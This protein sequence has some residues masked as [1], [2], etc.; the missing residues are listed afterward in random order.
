M[1]IVST[2]IPEVDQAVVRPAL[3]DILTQ[4]Q[5]VL[6]LPSDTR[7]MYP[8]EIGVMPVAGSYLSDEDRRAIY[9][10]GKYLYVEIDETYNEDMMGSTA[11]HRVEHP[12]HVHD[13]EIGLAMWTTYLNTEYTIN[14]RYTSASKNE[15]IRWRDDLYARLTQMRDM[16]VHHITYHYAIPPVYWGL[17]KDVWRLKARLDPSLSYEAYVRSCLSAQAASVASITGEEVNVVLGER[18]S[19]IIGTFDFSPMP[20]KITRDDTGIW[21]CTFG[22]KVRFD[23]PAL[24]VVRYPVMVYNRML[25]AKYLEW[26]LDRD[27]DRRHATIRSV[28]MDALAMFESTAQID[29]YSNI[30]VPYRIPEVDEMQVRTGPAGYASALSVLVEVDE[31]DGVS[32]FNL[33]ELS[34]YRLDEAIMQ[35]LRDGEYRYVSR[36]Y[37][38]FIYLGL[39]EDY[40]HLASGLIEVDSNLNLKSR[41]KLDLRR[42]HHVM[43]S[44]CVDLNMIRREAVERLKAN[45]LVFTKMLGYLNESLRDNPI[46]AAMAK[47]PR[48]SALD[49]S[50]LCYAIP[51]VDLNDPNNFAQALGG[52]SARSV[53]GVSGVSRKPYIDADPF[54]LLQGPMWEN[55][56]AQ[57]TGFSTVSLS[58]I[59]A[60]RN[61]GVLPS[62]VDWPQSPGYVHG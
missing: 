31:T 23:K 54:K 53:G 24:M 59:I 5:P 50:K 61:D 57:R 18:Q 30:Y 39:Y 45:A 52:R 2:T 55:L 48:V 32:L 41:I 9:N 20:E 15:A 3:I 25:P 1:P 21:T 17:L 4:L 16:L 29:G 10:T 62:S 49:F 11:S 37:E 7:I 33:D 40:Q 58:G 26:I 60:T 46:L 13:P 12:Y 35:Y 43:V 6:N 22:Y 38:S 14:V 42:V 56:R 27:D 51:G 47:K 34:P 19:R 44:L 36:P 8:G 28:S